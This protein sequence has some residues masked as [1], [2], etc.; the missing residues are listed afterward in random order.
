MIRLHFEKT[1]S[2]DRKREH[3]Y[4]GVPFPKEA[5]KT[6]R[7]ALLDSEGRVYP[8]SLRT[9]ACWDDGSVRWLFVRG[10]ADLPANAGIDYY[11]DP[12]RDERGAF[13]PVLA[14]DN[15]I[16]AGSL[17]VSLSTGKNCLFDSVSFMGRSYDSECISAPVLTDA[18]GVVY[19]FQIDRW[20]LKEDSPVCTVVTGEGRHFCGE[21][22]VYKA[23]INLTFYAEKDWFEMAYQIVNTT[24]RPLAIKSLVL[25]HRHGN[26][27][28]RNTVAIS[29]RRTQFLTGERVE[30]VIDADYLRYEANEHNAEV[31]Y[32]VFFADSADGESGLCATVFQAQQNFPK[33]LCADESGFC[34]KLVPE[35]V[36]EVVLES[37]M[38]REQR[39]LFHFHQKE[40]LQALNNRSTLYEMPDRPAISPQVFREAGVW[41]DIFCDRK[42][43][44]IEMFLTGKAD[45]HA[46]CY[47]MLHWGDSPDMGYT[48]Q[49]RGKGELVWTN[50]EYDFPHACALMYA[51]T[52]C[53]RYMDYV[54]VS[55]RHWMDVDIC[56][57][58]RNP[59]HRNGQWEHTNGHCKNGEI[60]CSHQWVEGLLDYYHLTGDVEA[61]HAALGI[62]ENVRRLLETPV[63]QKSGQVSARETGWALRTLTALYVE[64]NDA[65]WLEKCDWIVGH[66]RE[67]REEFGLWLSPYMD[68][69]AIRVVFMIAVAIGSLMRYYRIN[70]EPAIKE[71]ILEAVDD[72]L[73]NARLDNG[74]FYYKELPSLRRPGNNPLI[75]EALAIAFEL[76]GDRK[77]LE[78]G[79]PTF[80]YV[81]SQKTS[82]ASGGKTVVKDALLNGTTGTKGFAQTFLPF[83]TFYCACAR[84]GLLS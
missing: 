61:Y 29:N 72:L 51:R 18:A 47:G 79:L 60:V 53:R 1:Y 63:F 26:R 48:N 5:L 40:D 45:E 70:R 3:F 82:G 69:T 37:G 46:R 33:A 9:T 24:D 31:F 58:S 67:W 42:D 6:A 83:T 68:N 38:A 78:A 74:L 50:N 81:M 21:E 14:S 73:E 23:R 17:R 54:L 59:L 80:R 44:D 32:G 65:R 16:E 8:S 35:N 27:S 76:T 20:E 15:R 2:S 75:L 64:T 84:E 11:F 7:G 41:G 30:Q 4:F 36:T 12:E 43:F 77:Y 52:G 57:Y 71:M 10:M 49:G 19:D 39:V 62:G 25:R 28:L 66:F 56:H 13:S 55:G 22:S 34:V